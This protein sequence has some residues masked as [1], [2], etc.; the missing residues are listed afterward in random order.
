MKDRRR[1]PLTPAAAE[2]QLE[3]AVTGDEA[4][5]I[6]FAFARQYFEYAALF[7]VHGDLAAGYD[8]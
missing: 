4:L 8:A 1:G 6:F 7:V 5:G 3:D 2:L